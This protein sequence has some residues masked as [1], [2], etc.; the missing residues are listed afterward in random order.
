MK[1]LKPIIGCGLLGILCISCGVP[2][3]VTKHVAYQSVRTEYAQPIH[4][5]SIPTEAKISVAYTLSPKGELTA[6]V[7]NRTS[8]IMII[9]QTK[10][11]FV[12]SDGQSIS[13]YDPT[14]RTTSTTDLASSSKGASVNVGAIAGALGVGGTLGKIANGINVSGSGTSG[15]AV[16]NA[17][18]IT[19]QPQISLA[20]K[21]KADMSK[22][23]QVNG[24]LWGPW[25][26][27][28][29]MLLSITEQ[30]SPCRFSVCIS[31]STDGGETFE[32]LVTNFY[33]DSRICV[34]VEKHGAVNEAL[35]QVYIAK[36]DVFYEPWSILHFDY[37]I[38]KGNP[39]FVKGI[40]YDFQ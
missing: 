29:T 31:Y 12:N 16:S 21:G 13:Y 9:D 11:F 6:T 34:P 36:P 5:D 14:V 1:I 24:L 2:K 30:N 7:S 8:D 40:L 17:T 27:A 22:V 35:R 37:N 26:S 38:E 25:V 23:F 15:K 19:D 3:L 10:S 20:P 39:N 28:P 18:Y 32:K 33:V 4:A